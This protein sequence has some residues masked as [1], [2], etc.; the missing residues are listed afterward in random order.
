MSS[1]EIAELTGK[2]H[3]N[4][5]RDIR[6]LA[7]E[8]SLIFE[9][10]SEPSSGGRPSRVYL[11]EKRE[12]LILVSG[13]S[14]GLRTKIIDRWQELENKS[15]PVDIN[16]ALNNPVF[17]RGLLGN[18][19]ERVEQLEGEIEG[20]K[21]SLEKLDRIESAVGSLCLRDAAKT[22]KVQP[23]KFNTFL[24]TR[25][26]MHKRAGS[27]HWVAYQDKIQAGYLEHR[28]YIYVDNLGQERVRTQV[29]VTGK[30]L[31]KLAELLNQPL[32]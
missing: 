30:G 14:V 26:W 18:Y 15:T 32:Q 10:K 20:M 16:L 4:V 25:R 17:L 28:D 5:R 2:E 12:T 9:E 21:P 19:A 23:L 31:V 24:A 8:L 7:K 1:R 11:L 27:S 6:N 13:Y 3:D 29:M 22:L